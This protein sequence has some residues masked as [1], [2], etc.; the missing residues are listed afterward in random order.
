MTEK[1]NLF[2]IK[3]FDNGEVFVE[4]R[5]NNAILTKTT[6]LQYFLSTFGQSFSS[7]ET[8][9]IP[10]NCR[11]II[12]SSNSE[13]YIF[14]YA[15]HSRTIHYNDEYY[16]NVNC[17]RSLFIVKIVNNG[18]G[19]IVAKTDIFILDSLTPFNVNM[20]LYRWCFNNYYYSEGGRSYICWGSTDDNFTRILN[21]ETSGYGAFFNLYMSS[22]F[23][24]HLQPDITLPQHLKISGYSMKNFI[25]YMQNEKVFSVSNTFKVNDTIDSIVTRFKEGNY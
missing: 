15:A 18:A 21:G 13:L 19:K 3:I 24:D 12:K 20:D 8:P 23:N 17:P 25:R 1:Q 14:E 6:T 9:I 2:N 10:V 16:E 4:S 11:K 22:H 7:I 5:L